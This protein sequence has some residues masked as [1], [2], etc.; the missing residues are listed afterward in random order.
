MQGRVSDSVRSGGCASHL[1]DVCVEVTLFF[2]ILLRAGKPDDG[3][4]G[5]LSSGDLAQRQHSGPERRN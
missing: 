5:G 2:V 1:Q 3:P 4:R